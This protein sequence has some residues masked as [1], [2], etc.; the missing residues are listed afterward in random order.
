MALITY[1]KSIEKQMKALFDGLSE[2]DRRMYAA[3]E[4]NKL[5]R[6]GLKYISSLLGCSAQ[7]ILKG[8]KD[9]LEGSIQSGRI[10]K[11]GGGRKTARDKFP[12]LDTIFLK[13][14]KDHTAGDPMDDKV[15]WTDLSNKEIKR[16]IAKEGIEIN[17]NIV[18]KLL[19]H[20]GYSKC[21]MVKSK[22]IGS[23]DN[24][25]EQ[26]ENIAKLKEKYTASGQPVISMDTKKKSS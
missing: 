19:K 2:R 22:A 9:L 8:K 12:G 20:H 16:C 7:T 1:S 23:S 13:V 14:L 25:N 21:R 15:Q 10:R 26:F 4:V 17:K 3:V 6:G 5:E 11:P 18:A 24:R